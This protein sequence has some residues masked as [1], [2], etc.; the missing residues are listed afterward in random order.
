MYSFITH[1]WNTIK[2]ECSHGCVYCYMK[3]WGKQNP[4]R[5][6]EKELK[7]NLDGDH[8]IFVGSSNDMFALSHPD[9]WIDKTLQKCREAD[10]SLFFFQT[11]NPL[12]FMQKLYKG[13]IPEKSVVCTTIETNKV[14]PHIM[15]D[16]LSPEQRAIAMQ[17]I[18]LDKYVTIEPIMDFDI[19]E[20]VDIIKVVRPVQVNIGA[21]TGTLPFGFVEPSKEKVME[22]VEELEKFTTVH[23]K[24]NLKRIIGG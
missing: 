21:L 13:L 8:F 24:K 22:L 9:E 12:R 4:V 5:F 17:S 20:L 1:T 10:G 2:G 7:T 11:K 15:G 16:T 3:R 6:D 18:P 23:C 19:K 14:F